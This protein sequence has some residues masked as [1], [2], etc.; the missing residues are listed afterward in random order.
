MFKFVNDSI[1]I[2]YTKECSPT[3][4]WMFLILANTSF[5]A[6]IH[7]LKQTVDDNVLSQEQLL[8]LTNDS[9]LFI[10]L[11]GEFVDDRVKVSGME[12]TSVKVHVESQRN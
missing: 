4:M 10:S 6:Y 3:M 9:G 11:M 2:Y 1:S 12:E 7:T 8:A 5:K